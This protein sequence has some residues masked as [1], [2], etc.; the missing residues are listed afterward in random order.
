MGRR[1]LRITKE[2]QDSIEDF[3]EVLKNFE[4]EIREFRKS[5]N[6]HSVSLDALTSTLNI[7]QS[8]VADAVRER[9]ELGNIYYHRFLEEVCEPKRLRKESGT[10]NISSKVQNSKKRNQPATE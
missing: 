7:F 9:E 8:I 2:E 1:N 4:L 3:T 10:I 6:Y 5:F